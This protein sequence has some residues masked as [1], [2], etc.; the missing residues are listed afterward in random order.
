MDK[1]KE[2]SETLSRHINIKEGLTFDDILLVPKKG[3]LPSRKLADTST[4]IT[5]KIKLNIPII[6]ANMATVTESKMAIALARQGGL[7]VIHQ[8]MTPEQEAEEVKKVKRST[9][10]IIENPICIYDKSSLRQAKELMFD[11]NITSLMVINSERKLVGVLTSRDFQFEKNDNILITELMTKKQ[12][13]ILAE[14]GISF[15]RAQEILKNSK[16]EKLPLVDKEGILQGLVTAKDIRTLEKYPNATRDQK[17]RLRVGAAVGTRP[18]FLERASLLVENEVDLIVVDC[19]HGHSE[20]AINTVKTLKDSFPS[21]ELM[22]GNVA[23]Q[24]GTEDLIKAGADSIK[25]GIGAGAACTTRIIAGVGVPQI[26]A[27]LN[28]I[29][30]AKDHNIPIIA[31]GGIRFPGDLSKAIATGTSAIMIGRKLAGTLESPGRIIIKNGRRYKEYRGSSSYDQNLIN[32]ELSSGKRVDRID[33]IPEGIEGLIEYT[34]PVSELLNYFI[35]GL[36]SGIS[37]CG[38][39]NI[40]E[41]QKNAEFIKITAAGIEESHPHDIEKTK[42]N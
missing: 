18:G 9:S 6:S 21:I 39:T 33:V 1:L 2:I 19:A 24:E 10:Y 31:D 42:G 22:A 26:T 23:T 16:I 15:E 20:A 8:F 29:S 12:D 3:I 34:G 40:K 5:K 38:A 30:A 11:H 25:V 14:K 7:G 4:Y 37:Y 36:R 28:A 17:G 32:Q 35:G 13:L 27:V 41:M